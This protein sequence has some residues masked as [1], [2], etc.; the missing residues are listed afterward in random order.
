MRTL[1]RTFGGCPCAQI[2]MRLSQTCKHPGT[3]ALT[4]SGKSGVRGRILLITDAIT[5]AGEQDLGAIAKGLPEGITRIDTPEAFGIAKSPGDWFARLDRRSLP[6]CCSGAAR[7]W[8]LRD[9][10]RG[11]YRSRHHPRRD[12][13]EPRTWYPWRRSLP[14]IARAPGQPIE[15]SG[16]KSSKPRSPEDGLENVRSHVKTSI[17]RVIALCVLHSGHLR[18]SFRQ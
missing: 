8:H 5:T 18:K 1:P 2:G 3:L 16:P 11:R 9:Q 13:R 15:R 10:H 6:G 14:A 12:Q 17:R 4:W 7:T